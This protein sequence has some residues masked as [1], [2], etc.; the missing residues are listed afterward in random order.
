M[1]VSEACNMYQPRETNRDACEADTSSDDILK[2]IYEKL[3]NLEIGYDEIKTR[4]D[5]QDKKDGRSSR[6]AN[7]SDDQ[8]PSPYNPDADLMKA[9]LYKLEKVENDYHRLMQRAGTVKEGE[10]HGHASFLFL[11]H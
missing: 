1:T 4:M 6:F 2:A 7:S 8:Q 5:N 10:S 11:S 9:L 3:Q